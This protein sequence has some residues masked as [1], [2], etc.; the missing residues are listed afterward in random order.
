MKIK[1]KIRIKIRMKMEIKSYD[2]LVQ[3]RKTMVFQHYLDSFFAKKC[4][5]VD[6]NRCFT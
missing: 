3:L 1:I 4:K 6:K 2:V 5:F